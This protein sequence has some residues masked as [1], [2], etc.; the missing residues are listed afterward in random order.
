MKIIVLTELTKRDPNL[1]GKSG[2]DIN[3]RMSLFL[4]VESVLT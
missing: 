1:L 3:N 2:Y 4:F